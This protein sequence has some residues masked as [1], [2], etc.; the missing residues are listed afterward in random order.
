VR[1]RLDAGGGIH[2][3]HV[4]ASTTI[5]WS[6][7]YDRFVRDRQKIKI[8]SVVHDV[9][10][11]FCRASMPN[12]DGTM[13]KVECGGPGCLLEQAEND[14]RIAT[15]E[16]LLCPETVICPRRFWGFMFPIE[17]PAQQVAGVAGEEPRSIQRTIEAGQPMNIVIGFNPNLVQGKDHLDELKNLA[18]NRAVVVPPGYAGREGVTD[19]LE[20]KAAD[21]DIIYFFCHALESLGKKG[22]SL[23]F[24]HGYD[25]KIAQDVLEAADFHGTAFDHEPLV[26]MNGC[27]NVGFTPY[28]PSEFVKQFIQG[29]HASAVI[30]TEV[31]VWEVLAREFARVFFEHFLDRKTTAGDAIL[32]A[33][34]ALLVKNNPLGLIYTLFGSSQ[35]TIIATG[36]SRRA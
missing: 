23:D 30:G 36:E 24:G 8:G 5:P 18:K 9:T 31:T 13:P 6:L 15:N 19:I 17:V 25:N 27:G 1:E 12:A 14:R 2:A 4:D 34:R 26:F 21:A 28:A 33:R 7:V 16:P 22:P 11:G 20:A 32:A 35:L 29:R 10:R 3:A